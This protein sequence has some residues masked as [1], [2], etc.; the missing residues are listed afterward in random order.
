MPAIPSFVLLSADI[1]ESY[2][3]EITYRNGGL[4]VGQRSRSKRR[5]SDFESVAS[6]KQ[7]ML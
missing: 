6:A 7:R 4:R 3:T 1:K 2:R 5:K